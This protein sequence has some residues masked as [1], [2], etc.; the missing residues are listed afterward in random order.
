MHDMYDSKDQ[1]L[2]RLADK[3]DQMANESLSVWRL[4]NLSS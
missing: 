4:V 2:L 3:L 1:L